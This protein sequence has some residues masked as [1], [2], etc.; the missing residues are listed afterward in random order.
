M[1]LAE[2][3]KRKRGRKKDSANHID[4][5]VG[6]RIRLRRMLMGMSQE[7]LG[8]AVGL[9]FQ[10]IQKY[11]RGTNRV[12]ASRLY[13]LAEVL[14]VPVA[15]FFDEMPADM[16]SR[17]VKPVEGQGLHPPAF[18]PDTNP[19]AKREVAKLVRYYCTISDGQ[20]RRR[21]LDM[22]RVLANVQDEG[23]ELEVLE[24]A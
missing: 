17:A 4:A 11:E 23:E 12:S 13:D 9:T 24:S 1:N 8:E 21:L 10:Q 14:E 15:F 18:D 19:M 22:V 16:A 2:K 5:H 20:V 3:P 6:S 7:R